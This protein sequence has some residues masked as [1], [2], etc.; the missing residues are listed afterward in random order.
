MRLRFVLSQT[1]KGLRGNAAMAFSVTLVTFVSLLFLGG[2]VLLQWQINYLK[3]DWYD[4]VEVSAFMC[5]ANSKS[6]NCA[7]GEADKEQID[8]IQSFLDSE[9]MKPYVEKVYF[10]T[11]ED[12]LV[13]FK[14][15]M[16]DTPWADA[17]TAEQ[18][19]SSF[20]VK[21]VDPQK[22]EIVSDALAGRPGVESV[23]DQREQLA[24]LFRIMNTFTIIS[25]GLAA[26]MVV[27]AMLL[28]PS[29]I[30]LSAMF[31][32]NETEIM[33]YVGAS[34]RMVQMPFILEGI[35]A[36]LVGSLLAI[37]SLWIVV[38]VFIKN[39]AAG[40]WIRVLTVKDV[41]VLAPFLLV[42]AVLIASV[43]SFVALRKYTKV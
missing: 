26:V 33:R 4:K 40:S 23:Q 12:A 22:F 3:N 27:T 11:K 2:A 15:Q 37:G 32:K 39:W 36:A 42:A 24:P 38:G 43:A 29:T 31:R 5:P 20:R 10:E 34:N 18:L 25:G 30:R 9:Q 8:A 13:A 19:Q 6:P 35:L 7:D 14:K 28:I 17:I 1:F 16:A 21:L 41:L